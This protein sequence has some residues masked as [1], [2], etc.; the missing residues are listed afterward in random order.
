MGVCARSA[1]V[2]D[3][4]GLYC[5]AEPS[6]RGKSARQKS[7]ATHQK[8]RSARSYGP[9]SAN[10]NDTFPR[11]GLKNAALRTQLRISTWDV[12]AR[13]R[14]GGAAAHSPAAHICNRNGRACIER[15]ANGERH[16]PD[17]QRHPAIVPLRKRPA[18]AKCGR[19]ATGLTCARSEMLAGSERSEPESC[20]SVPLGCETDISCRR[21]PGASL[22]ARLIVRTNTLRTR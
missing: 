16:C 21:K 6:L 13:R 11:N 8:D 9:H 3:C 2:N 19:C 12:P 5:H 15:V 7:A 14:R 22:D 1:G 10:C 20:A 18:L 4:R 17:I